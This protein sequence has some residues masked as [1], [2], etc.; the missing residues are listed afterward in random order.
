MP[1]STWSDQR[2]TKRTANAVRT[3]KPRIPI[4][5]E[6]GRE[7]VRRVDPRIPGRK[8]PGRS[9]TGR[10][11]NELHLRRALRRPEQPLDERKDRER[12]EQVGIVAGS[13]STSATFAEAGSRSRKYD[14]RA[15]RVEDR[16]DGDGQQR[17][18]GTIAP[19]VSP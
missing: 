8:R 7:P 2:R 1:D 13:S 16:H 3:R 18:V 14:E 17:R 11:A 15:D 12:Q 19:V 5:R 10:L 4:R 6:L 9:G